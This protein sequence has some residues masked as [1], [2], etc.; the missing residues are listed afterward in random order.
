MKQKD[1]FDILHLALLVNVC[2]KSV[3]G[4]FLVPIFIAELK[5]SKNSVLFESPGTNSQIS[6]RTEANGLVP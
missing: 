5:T 6:G 3:Q 2:L 4:H 1:Q